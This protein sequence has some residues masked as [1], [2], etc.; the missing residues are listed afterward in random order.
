LPASEGCLVGRARI[1][2]ERSAALEDS[3]RF[4]I[5]VRRFRIAHRR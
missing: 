4:V 5:T 1:V 3:S 2:G